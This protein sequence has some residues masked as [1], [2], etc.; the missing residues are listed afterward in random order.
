MIAHSLPDPFFGPAA[1]KHGATFVVDVA[2][3]RPSLTAQNVVV[4]IGAAQTALKAVLGPLNYQDLDTI[5]GFAGKLT[6]T[7]FMCRHVFDAMKAAITRGELGEGADQLAAMRVT[8]SETHLAK[9]WFEAW[10]AIPGDLAAPTG[11]YE[12]ARHVLGLLPW[13][14]H[15]PLSGGFPSPSASDLDQTRAIIA[16]LPA[17][18]LLMVDGLAYGAMA[19]DVIKAAAPPIV[20]LVHHP[21]CLEAGLTATRAAALHDSE[22]QALHLARRV[23]TTSAVTARWLAQEFAVPQAKLAVAEPG[24]PPRRR[25]T[26]SLGPPAQLLAVG[27][28]TPRKG[29]QVLMQALARLTALWR[30]TIVGDL[31]RDAACVASLHQTIAALHLGDRVVLA[32]AVDDDALEAF[33]DAANIFVSA[34]LH[35]GYG[36]AVATALAFGLPVVAAMSGALTETTPNLCAAPSPH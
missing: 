27:A 25:A 28:I 22:R 20:A 10:F 21:L 5:E 2:F 1:R 17:D 3:M 16:G 29:Y 9:A 18:G 6:T 4:D 7:E 35:E 24:T 36:M 11:G 14:T 12:Y 8:L 31:S 30:L 34:S 26:G 33:Y 15:L 23:I 32:G 13:L 19:D